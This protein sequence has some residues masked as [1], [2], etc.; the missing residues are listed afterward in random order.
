VI[1]QSTQAT[2]RSGPPSLFSSEDRARGSSWVEVMVRNLLLQR[3]VQ[4]IRAHLQDRV[5]QK[6]VS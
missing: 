6:L 4:L 1:V 2:Q 3:G 5:K